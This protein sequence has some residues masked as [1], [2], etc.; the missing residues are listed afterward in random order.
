MRYIRVVVAA[1]TVALALGLSSSRPNRAEA[2]PTILAQAALPVPYET[3]ATLEWCWVASARMVA[4]YYNVATPPQCMM[5]QQAY[6]PACCANPAM[7]TVPGS[8]YQIQSLIAGYGLHYSMLGGPVDGFTMLRLIQ[9]GH[10]IVI[11]LRLGHFAVISGITVV[12]TPNGPLGIA[13]V[14]DPY[15]GIQDVPLPTL[16]QQWDVALYVS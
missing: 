7:C 15:F 8:I 4:R 12:A 3:Q 11:H 5:L 10:P 1:L 6:G 14:L 13:H 16:Y 9:Q 2:Q